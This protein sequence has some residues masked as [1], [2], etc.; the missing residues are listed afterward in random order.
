MLDA[1]L[2]VAVVAALAGS[3]GVDEFAD[4]FFGAGPGD[5][6]PFPA[7]PC[8]SVR[9]V[10]WSSR[11]WRGRRFTVRADFPRVQAGRSGQGSH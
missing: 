5:V 9:L 1:G 6:E 2:S 7:G 10:A 4:G 8:W 11:R 3:V